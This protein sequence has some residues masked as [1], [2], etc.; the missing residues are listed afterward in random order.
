MYLMH[1]V[2][3]GEPHFAFFN[4]Y[5]NTLREIIIIEYSRNH[6]NRISNAEKTSFCFSRLSL[7]SAFASLSH[8]IKIRLDYL[9]GIIIRSCLID[10]RYREKKEDEK[11]RE[12][13]SKE[14]QV[15]NDE[16]FHKLNASNLVQYLGP[17]FYA[18]TSLSLGTRLERLTT[19][20]H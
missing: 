13:L 20:N 15:T 16:S 10:F 4:V 1:N 3:S 18:P 7:Y 8:I 9:S 14:P 12:K 11:E 2:W 5:L 17:F 19:S 6:H